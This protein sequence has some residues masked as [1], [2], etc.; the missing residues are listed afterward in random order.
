MA[1]HSSVA[2]RI[3]GTGDPGGLPSMGSQSQKWLKR[4]SSSSSS[5][6]SELIQNALFPPWSPCIGIQRDKNR[7]DV[8]FDFAELE[9]AAELDVLMVS[10]ASRGPE[11]LGVSQGYRFWR[12]EGCSWLPSSVQKLLPWF[13]QWLHTHECNKEKWNQ[14]KLSKNKET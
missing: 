1:T 6:S 8:A 5:S 14:Q 13:G 11:G 9:R 10:I 2:W 4:L 3:P 12:A 7:C